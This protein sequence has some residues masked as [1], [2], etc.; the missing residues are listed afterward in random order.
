MKKISYQH[1]N[2][3]IAH[4][5]AIS[6]DEKKKIRLGKMSNLIENDSKINTITTTTMIK[7][8]NAKTKTKTIFPSI[9]FDFSEAAYG[10]GLNRDESLPFDVSGKQIAIEGILEPSFLNE[11]KDQKPTFLIRTHDEKIM[12]Q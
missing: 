4:N 1:E 3:K 11:I 10:H 8:T 5:N 9:S 6:E 2:K 7:K 12:K